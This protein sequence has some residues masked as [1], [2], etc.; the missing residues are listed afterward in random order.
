MI[1]EGYYADLAVV[2]LSKKRIIQKSH[3]SRCS[4][5]PWEEKILQGDVVMT[6][7]GGEIVYN[8]G[9]F[10]VQAALRNAQEIIF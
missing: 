7:L 10:N 4:W 9:C 8:E 2:D 5:S 1:K 6:I 3:I